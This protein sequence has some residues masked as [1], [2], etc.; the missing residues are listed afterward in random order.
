MVWV[1]KYETKFPV[2]FR[3]EYHGS[4]YHFTTLLAPEAWESSRKTLTHRS[5]E[6][7]NRI[8]KEQINVK[9]QPHDVR[10]GNRDGSFFTFQISGPVGTLWE[11]P[12][13]VSDGGNC[14]S[15]HPLDKH[16]GFLFGFQLGHEQTCRLIKWI[17]RQTS[18]AVR[19]EQNLSCVAGATGWR[20]WLG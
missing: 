9:G 17:N 4:N 8:S 1:Q 7:K 15:H 13:E 3:Q 20:S 18:A 16:E 2:V 14:H 12:S 6:I 5:S 10:D 19:T 11:N